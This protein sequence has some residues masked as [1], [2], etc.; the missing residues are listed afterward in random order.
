M[1]SVW[2]L[3]VKQAGWGGG[4][5]QVDVRVFAKKADAESWAR[6]AAADL[7]LLG[8]WARNVEL[9]CGGH[10]WWDEGDTVSFQKKEVE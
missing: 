10:M 8:E 1:K 5:D 9:D 6:A 4:D 7:K 3:E 2:V